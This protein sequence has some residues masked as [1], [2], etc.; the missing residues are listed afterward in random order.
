MK[1]KGHKGHSIQFKSLE[2]TLL[3]PYCLRNRLFWEVEKEKEG[4]GSVVFFPYFFFLVHKK[5]KKL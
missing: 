2:P 3:P 4:D 1:E 5:K